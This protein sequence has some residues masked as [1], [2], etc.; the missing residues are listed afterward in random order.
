M[1]GR[2]TQGRRERLAGGGGGSSG[3]EKATQKECTPTRGNNTPQEAT[4]TET[5]RQHAQI[6]DI[7]P[8]KATVTETER[9]RAPFQ[10]MPHYNEKNILED[11]K[12]YR[13]QPER[14]RR[15]LEHPHEKK[16]RH[17]RQRLE[18]PHQGGWTTTA[19]NWGVLY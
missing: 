19:K 11:R 8:E 14:Y 6:P 5:E 7:T 1:A 10:V 3:E 17:N 18:N 9:L 16:K 2:N 15:E 4:V 12:R 13:Q